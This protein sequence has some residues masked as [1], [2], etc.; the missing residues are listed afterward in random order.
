[1]IAFSICIAV[2]FE[3]VQNLAYLQYIV[4]LKFSL[5]KVR[6]LLLR[7]FFY[8]DKPELLLCM[9]ELL[10]VFIVTITYILFYFL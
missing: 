4:A 9:P 10:Y 1:M 8:L 7:Y 6:N 3:S 5:P 2:H